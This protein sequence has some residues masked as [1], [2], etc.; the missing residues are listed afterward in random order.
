VKKQM[1]KFTFDETV[2]VKKDAPNPFRQGQKASVIMVFLPQ[3]RCGSYFDQF[4]PGVIYSIE[5]EDGQSIDIHEELL[6]NDSLEA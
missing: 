5:Y 2:R 6:E 1:N 3:D 4:A